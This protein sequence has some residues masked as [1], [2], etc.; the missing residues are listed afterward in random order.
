MVAGEGYERR[1]YAMRDNIIEM[2]EDET[3]R[4]INDVS[5]EVGEIIGRIYDQF[6]KDLS[7][8]ND[9]YFF[10]AGVREAC[11]LF[12]KDSNIEPNSIREGLGADR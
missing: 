11:R 4:G 7:A 2:L 6:P 1:L 12:A 9:D 8:N 3:D 10:G 5:K